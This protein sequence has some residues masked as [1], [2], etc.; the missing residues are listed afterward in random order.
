MRPLLFTAAMLIICSQ[1]FAQ[2]ININNQTNFKDGVY[3]TYEDFLNN[4]PSFPLE[5]FTI[6]WYDT[7]FFN[8]LKMK[9][10]KN[11]VKGKLK[12][13]DMN[14]IWGFCMNGTPYIQYSIQ[15]PYRILF[16]NQAEQANGKS[17]FTRLRILGNLCHFSIEDYYPKRTNPTFRDNG[18]NK[19]R[20]GRM[21]RAQRVLKLATGRIYEYDEYVLSQLFK[22][23][24]F[25]ASQF[26]QESNRDQKL[27]MYLQKYNER[28]PVANRSILAKQ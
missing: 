11:F 21:V 7:D 26:K 8:V 13:S 17:S 27:F 4:E 10:C 16:G 25:L 24:T 2:S 20:H 1:A 9:S 15:L 23:D 3:A 19:E 12:K 22:D 28:N 18:F 6:K 5:A 14:E